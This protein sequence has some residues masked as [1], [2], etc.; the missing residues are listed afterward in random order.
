PKAVARLRASLEAG[1]SPV[2]KKDSCSSGTGLFAPVI[3]AMPEGIRR[4]LDTS[5][6]VSG[7]HDL[8]VCTLPFVHAPRALRQT[9][10]TA[11]PPHAS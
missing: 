7:P 10:A 3:R 5:I 2:Y 6:G 11:S 9:A 8:T 4:E 1:R